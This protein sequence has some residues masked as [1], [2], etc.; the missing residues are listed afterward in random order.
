MKDLSWEEQ[1]SAPPLVI[2]IYWMARVGIPI[3]I[4]LHDEA[5]EKHPEYFPE[6]VELRKKWALVPKKLEEQWLNKV[7]A[8]NR[9]YREAAPPLPEGGLMAIV[10]ATDENKKMI[11]WRAY[12]DDAHEVQKKEENELF[13]RMFNEY[14]LNR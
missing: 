3:G 5:I 11:A 2:Q 14:G 12:W 6:E 4:S 13:N 8:I 1:H 10:R 9:K 7:V